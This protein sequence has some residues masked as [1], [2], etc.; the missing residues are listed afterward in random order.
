MLPDF[1]RGIIVQTAQNYRIAC[2]ISHKIIVQGVT[3]QNYYVKIQKLYDN[4]K[5]HDRAGPFW[6]AKLSYNYRIIVHLATL[7]V[8][9]SN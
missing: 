2:Q 1:Q 3:D 4:Y 5:K 6:R 8:D 9:N 7:L